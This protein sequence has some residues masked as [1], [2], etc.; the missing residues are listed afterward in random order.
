MA[1]RAVEPPAFVPEQLDAFFA[2]LGVPPEK[3]S[4][5]GAVGGREVRVITTTTFT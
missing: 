2:E 3:R 4:R 5:A 1:E